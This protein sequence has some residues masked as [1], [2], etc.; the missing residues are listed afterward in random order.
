[1][2]AAVQF[3]AMLASLADQEP[4]LRSNMLAQFQAG[5]FP[6][7]TV[8]TNDAIT[9]QTQI[10]TNGLPTNV[11]AALSA[12]GVDPTTISNYQNTLLT[13]DAG[14]LAGTFPGSLADTNLDATAHTL[15]ADLRDASLVLINASLLPGGQFRFDLPTEPGYTYNIQSTANLA[16]PTSWATLFTTNAAT[17]LLSFTNPPVAGA[18]SAFFRASHN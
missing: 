6:A 18:Q 3:E 16:D 13:A 5:G 17:T 8:T 4:A 10:I 2:N 1:M 12:Q 14:S 9:L 11:V 15:G 7:I